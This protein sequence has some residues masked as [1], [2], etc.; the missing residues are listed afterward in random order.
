MWENQGAA[1][2]LA[3]EVAS[4]PDAFDL[5]FPRIDLSSERVT[6][7]PADIN[8]DTNMFTVR[9]PVLHV[10]C[11]VPSP[12]VFTER[13]PHPCPQASL[14]ATLNT[15]MSAL[16]EIASYSSYQGP[17]GGLNDAQKLKI[18]KADLKKIKNQGG[19]PEVRTYMQFQVNT[20][21]QGYNPSSN[22]AMHTPTTSAYFLHCFN[23]LYKFFFERFCHDLWDNHTV[24][25]RAWEFAKVR[26]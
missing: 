14:I 25:T 17:A 5:P 12:W 8:I 7:P 13:P 18:L 23:N 16:A 3:M 2:S 19:W 1:T 22:P 20:L 6:T 26:I 11:R 4:D 21:L 15:S 24:Q 9:R 10:P